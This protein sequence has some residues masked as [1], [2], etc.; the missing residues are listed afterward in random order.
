MLMCVKIRCSCISTFRLENYS[1][2][3][4]VLQQFFRNH[5][6]SAALAV[7]DENSLLPGFLAKNLVIH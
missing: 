3:S 4:S 6:I 5:F 7:I 1:F 2:N